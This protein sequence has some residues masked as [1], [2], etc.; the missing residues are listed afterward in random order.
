MPERWHGNHR[1]YGANR[2]YHARNR[3]TPRITL[4]PSPSDPAGPCALAGLSTG[5]PVARKPPFQTSPKLRKTLSVSG[6]SMIFSIIL[7]R[8]GVILSSKHPHVLNSLHVGTY[9]R[10]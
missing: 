10:M 3:P 5:T 7:S 6:A 8:N 4:L 1:Q 9:L 2:R